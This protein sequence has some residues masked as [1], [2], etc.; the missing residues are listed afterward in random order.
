[1][2]VLLS[3]WTIGRIDNKLKVENKADF[4]HNDFV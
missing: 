2:S 3:I 1:M 4:G